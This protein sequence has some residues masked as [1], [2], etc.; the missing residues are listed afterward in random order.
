MTDVLKL[1][2]LI[3]YDIGKFKGQD[4]VR[5]LVKHPFKN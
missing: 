2:V 5:I 4:I 1:Y 3:F